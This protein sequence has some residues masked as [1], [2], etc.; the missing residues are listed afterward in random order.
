MSLESVDV[1]KNFWYSCTYRK[2]TTTFLF[3]MDILIGL[4][5]ILGIG[6]G[7]PFVTMIATDFKHA[8]PPGK[9]DDHVLPPGDTADVTY[10]FYDEETGQYAVV[11]AIVQDDMSTYRQPRLSK[12]SPRADSNKTRVA[13]RALALVSSS[14]VPVRKRKDKISGQVVSFEKCTES[15]DDDLKRI[16]DASSL[17]YDV[18][19]SA[20]EVAS[21]SFWSNVKT[22]AKALGRFDSGK[23][24]K[25]EN[26]LRRSERLM[27]DSFDAGVLAGQIKQAVSDGTFNDIT[28]EELA[29]INRDTDQAQHL[30]SEG[31]QLQARELLRDVKE[32]VVSKTRT[33]NP[34]YIEMKEMES[35]LLDV[36]V[37][38][39]Q[40]E[41]I[42]AELGRLALELRR[43]SASR[44]AE[45]TDDVVAEISR[46]SDNVHRYNI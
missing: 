33:D 25:L 32:L 34:A 12:I 6:L 11:D 27:F 21:D 46:L 44:R 22:A 45:R 8:L 3:E 2:A 17:T 28:E 1:E 10:E 26:Q 4:A 30:V 24:A 39:S 18:H 41:D 16:F 40:N 42:I 9:Q 19:A 5:I 31:R 36:D 14:C 38:V 7:V 37:L 23:Y 13:K 35:E 15:L 20:V 43:A 29:Q